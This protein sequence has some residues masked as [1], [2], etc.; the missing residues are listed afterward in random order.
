MAGSR[1]YH[2][3][4]HRSE[5]TAGGLDSRLRVLDS[6]MR[7]HHLCP[8]KHCTASTERRTSIIHA[9]TRDGNQVIRDNRARCVTIGA[10]AI[11]TRIDR[12]VSKRRPSH[13]RR[14]HR[15]RC[16]RVVAT[17]LGRRRLY[18]VHTLYVS[19]D[20]CNVS[21]LIGAR[22]SVGITNDVF[23]ENCW[24]SCCYCCC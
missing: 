15:S 13:H 24:R 3:T 19:A 23:I 14:R 10:S 5:V 21:R 17:L 2:S 12:D 8:L 9:Q 11:L 7:F 1:R 18:R 22:T 16:S 6:Q 20:T 4:T